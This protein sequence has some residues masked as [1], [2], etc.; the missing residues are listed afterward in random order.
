[1]LVGPAVIQ[2]SSG[3]TRNW[4]GSLLP[5]IVIPVAFAVLWLLFSLVSVGS[6]LIRDGSRISVLACVGIGLLLAIVGIA[7]IFARLPSFPAYGPGP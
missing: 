6:L 7:L 4:S 5:F 2:S 1:V 3:G